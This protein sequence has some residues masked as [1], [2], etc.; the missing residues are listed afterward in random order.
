MLTRAQLAKFLSDPDAIRAMERIFKV[1]DAAEDGIGLFTPLAPLT[2]VPAGDVVYNKLST[3]P[4]M[5]TIKIP[6]ANLVASVAAAHTLTI[7]T[8]VAG[9][10]TVVVPISPLGDVIDS[11]TLE[12]V[13]EVDED[14]NVTQVG[15]WDIAGHNANGSYVKYDSGTMV[16]THFDATLRATGIGIGL[17]FSQAPSASFVGDPAVSGGILPQ[18]NWTGVSCI[19]AWNS[20]AMHV[21]LVNSS[22]AQNFFNLQMTAVGWWK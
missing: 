11:G 21:Y 15:S 6:K 10:D 1:G 18:S 13:V 3:G 17:D 4:G 7:S 19:G 12:F 2:S 16:V 9:K 14:G 22:S 5:Y 8:G 20:G